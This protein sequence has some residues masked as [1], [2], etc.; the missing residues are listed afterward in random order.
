MYACIC[1]LKY[2][3]YAKY[4]IY[5]CVCVCVKHGC[6]YIYMQGMYKIKKNIHQNPTHPSMSGINTFFPKNLCSSLESHS[7]NT[8]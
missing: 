5:V 2:A 3:F 1:I 6:S 4:V 8:F 7:T